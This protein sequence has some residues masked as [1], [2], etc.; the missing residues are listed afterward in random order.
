MDDKEEQKDILERWRALSLD[1]QELL[2]AKT[3]RKGFWF[4]QIVRI[5]VYLLVGAA[6]LGLALLIKRS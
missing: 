5:V 6:A 2:L 1:E 3:N 4:F